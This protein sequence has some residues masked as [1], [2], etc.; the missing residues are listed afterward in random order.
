MADIRIE[1]LGT[2]WSFTP[3]NEDAKKFFRDSL[4]IEPWQ[5]LGDVLM[6][7]HRPARQLCE[8]LVDEGF[9]LQIKICRSRFN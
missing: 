9:S 5:W 8:Y 3:L 6:V 4:G 2:M 1:D 7:D